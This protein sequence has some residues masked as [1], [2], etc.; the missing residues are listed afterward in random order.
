MEYDVFALKVLKRC[1]THFSSGT[2]WD[3]S[4]LL[5][6]IDSSVANY[7]YITALEII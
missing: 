4:S 3:T 2:G 1:C 5:G 6:V 7:L